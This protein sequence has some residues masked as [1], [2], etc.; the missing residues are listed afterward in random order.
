MSEPIKL[1]FGD[2][3][4]VEGRRFVIEGVDHGNGNDVAPSLLYQP[5]IEN[6]EVKVTFTYR[7]EEPKP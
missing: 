3:I 7:P 1:H 2:V 4:E 6:I 5:C